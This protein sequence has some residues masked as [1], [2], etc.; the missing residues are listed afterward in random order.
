MNETQ[1]AGTLLGETFLNA[2]RVAVRQEIR[3]TL[4]EGGFS[5]DDRLMDA[6]EASKLLAVSKDW[7]YRHARQ[8]PC[9]GKAFPMRDYRTLAS[10]G[11]VSGFG[12][13]GFGGFVS[14]LRNLRILYSAS[15]SLSKTRLAKSVWARMWN[16]RCDRIGRPGR[17]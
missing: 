17:S 14:D 7:L 8:L 9:A 2:I 16:Q 11:F 6:D 15:S 13:R 5:I 10:T 1:K 3:A 12:L 4:E